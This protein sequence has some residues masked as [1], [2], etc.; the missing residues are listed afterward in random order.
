MKARIIRYLTET[1]FSTLLVTWCVIALLLAVAIQ[2]AGVS[3]MGFTRFAQFLELAS[4]WLLPLRLLVYGSAAYSWWRYSRLALSTSN[5]PDLER[6]ARNRISVVCAI[7]IVALEYG[8][9]ASTK[10]ILVP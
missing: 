3:A 2:V 5:S 4:P 10:E 7:Y 8:S 9:W 6:R 1:K